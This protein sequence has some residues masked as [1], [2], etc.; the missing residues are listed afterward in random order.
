MGQRGGQG[1]LRQWPKGLLHVAGEHEC[2]L[3][4]ELRE[5][6]RTGHVGVE[7][8]NAGFVVAERGC[9]GGGEEGGDRG[10]S[11]ACDGRC[12]HTDDLQHCVLPQEVERGRN[13]GH[14]RHVVLTED[15]L[16]G[17]REAEAARPR[18]SLDL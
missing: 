3:V 14:Q 16:V 12:R 18:E 4:A 10:I 7:E 9:R 5:D 1:R 2:Q 8:L 15:A 11:D 17:P 13:V 6:L